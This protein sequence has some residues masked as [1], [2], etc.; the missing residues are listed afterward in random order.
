MLHDS[1]G[2][3]RTA[4]WT[5]RRRDIRQLDDRVVLVDGPRAVEGGRA[6]AAA[7]R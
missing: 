2:R 4:H 1:R 7:E 6:G 5:E 3:V